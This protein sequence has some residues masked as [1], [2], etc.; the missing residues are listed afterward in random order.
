M[1]SL[2]DQVA[3]VTDG[4]KGIGRGIAETLADAGATVVIADLDATQGETT[5]GEIG[6]VFANRST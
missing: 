6:G 4:A 1:F 2:R 5:A 3:V